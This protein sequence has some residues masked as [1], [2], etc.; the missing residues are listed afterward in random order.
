MMNKEKL[1]QLLEDELDANE[2][3]A[4][5]DSLLDDPELQRAWLAQ[6]TARAALRDNAV[7]A[8][9]DMVD[10][11]AEALEDETAIIAP[12]NLPDPR[13][14]QGPIGENVIPLRARRKRVLAFAAMAASV[15]A[16]VFISYTPDRSS[17][18]QIADTETRAPQALEDEMQS[19]I[20]Q[21]GEVS[22]A[23][24]LN[25]LVAYAKVVNGSTRGTGR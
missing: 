20:V 6:C 11:V 10:R 17:S 22:G 23:T 24:A 9:L 25:G 5:I 18:P 12:H 21:H 3:E 2:A 16:L 7:H 1:S 19:M 15:A 13:T 8:S 14:A 4:V